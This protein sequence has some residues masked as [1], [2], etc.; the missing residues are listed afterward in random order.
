MLCTLLLAAAPLAAQGVHQGIP[1]RVLAPTVLLERFEGVFLGRSGDTLLFG[2]DE[3]G[4][5]RVPLMAVTQLEVSG[6]KSRVRGML[7]GALWGGGVMGATAPLVTS[8]SNFERD[9]PGSSRIEVAA[10]MLMV[11]AVV[12]GIIGIFL[13]ARVWRSADPRLLLTATPTFAR[14]GVSISDSG[15]APAIQARVFPRM[16]ANPAVEMTISTS[17]NEPEFPGGQFPEMTV[18]FAVNR[19]W[20]PNLGAALVADIDVI[21]DFRRAMM[22]G[23]RIYRRSGP[24]FAGQRTVTYFGQVLAGTVQSE[25][26]GVVRSNG[27]FGIQPGAGIEVGGGNLALHVQIAHRIVPGGFVE[28]DRLPGQKTVLSGPRYVGGL[29]WRLLSR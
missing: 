12:G 16:G 24:L 17:V 5:V 11:G 14:E 25:E 29:T 19:A 18:S 23:P 3:R 2:N 26:S 7:R 15:S 1:V 21:S 8:D 20:R 6:G 27:G 10:E 9:Y 28:D 13:P 22:A 4:P